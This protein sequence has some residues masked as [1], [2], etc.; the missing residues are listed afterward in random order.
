MDELA[1]NFA[2]QTVSPTSV[3][4]SALVPKSE[5][6]GAGQNV[7]RHPSHPGCS[8]TTAFQNVVCSAPVAVVVVNPEAYFI[9]ANPAAEALLGYSV[10][11]LT[12]KHITDIVEAEATWVASEFEHLMHHQTWSGRVLLR[13][14]EGDLLKVTVNAFSSPLPEGGAEH[15]ALLDSTY[16]DG[17]AIDRVPEAESK[18]GLTV[19]DLRLLHLIAAGFNDAEVADILG[20]TEFKLKAD[21]AAIR[22][23]M[24]V[25]S[26]TEA[27]ITGVRN[28]LI[29]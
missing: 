3:R 21:V 20:V 8:L 10:S 4:F 27:V 14:L 17:P 24:D 29:V 19:E 11:Q 25:S 9:Y 18:I 15:V 6:G 5:L 13:C 26:M 12:E 23:K 28:R 22:E 2:D 1:S 16:L 7:L